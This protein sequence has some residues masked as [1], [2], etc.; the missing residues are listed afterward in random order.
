[1]RLCAFPSDVL[2]R[3]IAGVPAAPAIASSAMISAPA[4][5]G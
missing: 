3:R 5:F 1:M 2:M 4:G